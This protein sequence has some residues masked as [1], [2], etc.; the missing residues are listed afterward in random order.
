[1]IERSRTEYIAGSWA[2]EILDYWTS[3][4]KHQC[5][6]V[7]LRV[8]TPIEEEPRIKQSW[9]EKKNQTIPLRFAAIDVNAEQF[10]LLYIYEHNSLEMRQWYCKIQRRCL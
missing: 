4:P 9:L 8:A 1:M 5:K 10:V 7:I 2:N 6:I 3:L